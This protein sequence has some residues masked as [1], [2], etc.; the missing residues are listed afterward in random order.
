MSTYFILQ[1]VHL[2][3]GLVLPR[4]YLAVYGSEVNGVVSTINSFI[5][6]F[7]YLEAGIGLTLIHSLF[8]PLAEKDSEKTNKILSFSR[9][10][11]VRI[12]SMYALL[13]I[14]F[15]VIF[16]FTSDTEAL[17][18]FEFIALIL[19]IGVS[20]TMDFY[21]MAKYRV[22]LTADSKEYVISLSMII[23]Q[24]LRF[25]FVGLMLRLEVSIVIVKLVPIL[26]IIIRSIILKCYIKKKYPQVS[27][28]EP[29]EKDLVSTSK[30][31]DALL[32]QIAINSSVVLPVIIVSQ[33]LG[34]VDANIYAVYSAVIGSMIALVACLSSGVSPMLGVAIA[35]K[36]DIKNTYDIYEW[37]VSVAL[38]IIF[39]V[40]V[41]MLLPFV[42]LYVSV[43]NDVNYIYK[44][45]AILFT[46]WAIIYVFRMPSTALVNATGLYRENRVNNILNLTIQVALGIVLTILFGINGMLITMIIAAL[47]RNIFFF[48]ITEK[49]VVQGTI[50]KSIKRQ[51]VM[52]AV[53]VAS[54]LVGMDFVYENSVTVIEWLCYATV[55]TLIATVITLIVFVATDIRTAKKAIHRFKQELKK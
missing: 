8:K 33:I 43:V 14:L 35:E 55:I 12:S 32:L 11:Y 52:T 27:F 42:R 47:Q 3:V 49:K 48:C 15:S 45:Y 28:K 31:W 24:V 4:L 38:T 7:H 25:V 18:T 30:R 39:S 41:V 40:G 16:P 10:Q 20:G 1:I 50:F 54:A 2:L 36:K 46:I 29:F 34:Y 17:S 51:F 6:Y 37:I 19:V 21:T 53:V 5:S 13:V 26:S 9:N 23:S 44:S 22:L